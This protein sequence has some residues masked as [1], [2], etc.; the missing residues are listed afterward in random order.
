MARSS[1]RPTSVRHLDSL[2][3][4]TPVACCGAPN[5]VHG[6][7]PLERPLRAQAAAHFFVLPVSTAP[8]PKPIFGDRKPAHVAPKSAP[9]VRRQRTDAVARSR[10]ASV[11]CHQESLSGDCARTSPAAVRPCPPSGAECLPRSATPAATGDPLVGRYLA[12]RDR[13]LRQV[14][15]GKPAERHRKCGSGMAP[16]RRVDAGLAIGVPAIGSCLESS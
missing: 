11:G 10:A 4:S 7:A 8:P 9:P 6:G 16:H 14:A 15:R 3:C 1:V 5:T 12:R 13:S 2:N